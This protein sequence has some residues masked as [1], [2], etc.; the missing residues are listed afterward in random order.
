M[1]LSVIVFPNKVK[2]VFWD[3]PRNFAHDLI[4]TELL[5]NHIKYTKG[6]S[7]I[8]ISSTKSFLYSIRQIIIF[9]Q[10]MMVILHLKK[11]LGKYWEI[12]PNKDKENKTIDNQINN[13]SLWRGSHHRT[14][15]IT[16]ERGK[17]HRDK[18]NTHLAHYQ[19]NP[20]AHK[21]PTCDLFLYLS[22][23]AHIM[24]ICSNR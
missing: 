14:Y 12:C 11:V 5:L 24:I 6:M 20:Y 23:K 1:M 22:V 9:G 2:M 21:S 18:S 7:R 15:S 17:I 8:H 19:S 16:K 3:T 10:Q 13:R 4:I